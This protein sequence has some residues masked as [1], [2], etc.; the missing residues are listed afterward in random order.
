MRFWFWFWL[1]F[2]FFSF[3]V[4]GM[5][6]VVVVVAVA[7]AFF[8]QAP[9]RQTKP[10]PNPHS[11]SKFSSPDQPDLTKPG[12]TPNLAK[13]NPGKPVKILRKRNPVKPGP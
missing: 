13:P 8:L 12:Q 7:V 5:V 1:Q 4:S 3:L 2:A 10:L 9:R 6:V 11:S